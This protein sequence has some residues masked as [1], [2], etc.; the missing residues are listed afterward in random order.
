MKYVIVTCSLMVGLMFTNCKSTKS[1][2]QDSYKPIPASFGQRTDSLNS[3]AISWK[4][5]FTDQNL[6]GLIDIALKNNLDLAIALQRIEAARAGFNGRKGALLPNLNVN[7]AY[8]QRKFGYYTMDDAGNRT[9]EITPG[10]MVPTHLPDFYL[11]LQTSWELDVWGKLRN[12]KKAAFSRYL[13]GIEGKN[14]VITNLIADVTN[15]YYELLAL[16]N[17][18]EIIQE[19]IKLQQNALDLVSIQKQ[20][21]AANELA[22]KQFKAQLLNS[23]AL[24]FETLQKITECENRINFLLGRY[25]QVIVRD[26]SEFNKQ[27]AFKPSVGIPSDLLKNRPDIRQAEFELIA[28]KADVKAARAAFYPSINITGSLGFQSFNPAFLFNTP[29]SI[30]YSVL[31][32]LMAP[33][34]NRSAIKAEFKTAKAIQEEALVNYQKSILTGYV[35]VYNEVARIQNLEKI[36]DLKSKEAEVLT[37]SIETSTELFKNARANYLEVLTTQKSSLIAKLEL[38]NAKKRQYNAMT[39]IYKALGGGWK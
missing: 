30:A 29:Q 26:K 17:E 27:L 12:K 23:Q 7:T 32:N 6:L 13:S 10:Q 5:Y 4:Q 9:T 25:P 1:V 20:A 3:G 37:Q 15:T 16:D 34:I 38:I 24:E 8:W 33:L 14:M 19:T 36:V 28:T 2:S 35:E 22:V 11:G 39:D 18:L 21:A 31:G